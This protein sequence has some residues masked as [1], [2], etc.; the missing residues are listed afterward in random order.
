[1][2]RLTFGKGIDLVYECLNEK[3]HEFCLSKYGNLSRCN[4]DNTSLMAI[5]PSFTQL[6]EGNVPHG[7]QHATLDS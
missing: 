4:G 6:C 5:A 7:P 2:F 3:T 1:M